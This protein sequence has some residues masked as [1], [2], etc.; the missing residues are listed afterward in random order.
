M[1]SIWVSMLYLFS[2]PPLLLWPPPRLSPAAP[3][4]L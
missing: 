3:F 4:L 1:W 2:A